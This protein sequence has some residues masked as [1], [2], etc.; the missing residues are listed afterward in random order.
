VESPSTN[1]VEVEVKASRY[2]EQIAVSLHAGTTLGCSFALGL[3]KADE[4]ANA[5]HHA[6]LEEKR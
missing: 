6:V 4:L 2:G 1:S 3:E 5:I